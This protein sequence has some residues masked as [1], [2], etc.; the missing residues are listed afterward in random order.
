MISTEDLERQVDSLLSENQ[1]LR[2]A[3]K[4]IHIRRFTDE[5]GDEEWIAWARDCAAEALK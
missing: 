1:K 2:T 3:L 4:E 5:A